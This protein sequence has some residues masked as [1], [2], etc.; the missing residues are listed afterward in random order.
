[1][2]LNSEH[3]EASFSPNLTYS[4]SLQLAQVPRSPEMGIFVSM[5]TTTMMI[6]LITLPRTHACG[7]MNVVHISVSILSQNG[8]YRAYSD[9]TEAKK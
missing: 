5:T 3:I 2:P 6:R 4:M 1:M 9:R 8:I 7:V